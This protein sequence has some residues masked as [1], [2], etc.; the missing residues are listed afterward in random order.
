MIE[1]FDTDAT[2]PTDVKNAV[3]QAVSEFGKIDILVSNAT[4]L[5]ALALF[6]DTPLDDYW[7]AFEVNV[8]SGITV[9]QE[10]LKIASS[11]AAIINITAGI[12]QGLSQFAPK[13][14]RIFGLEAG[15]FEYH[16]FYPDLEHRSACLQPSFG[17]RRYRYAMEVPKVS[18][19]K[20]TL[21]CK[22]P[23]ETQSPRKITSR[24][25]PSCSVLCF[26]C[27]S[28]GRLSEGK[29]RLD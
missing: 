22:H 12:A 24:T 18:R 17:H 5:P 27:G 14:S 7:R 26:A 10:F 25:R 11:N 2:S 15:G 23:V 4:Y 16:E 8:K 9:A 21:V 20:T 3:A 19:L 28:R 29:A 6:A 13:Y 1:Y